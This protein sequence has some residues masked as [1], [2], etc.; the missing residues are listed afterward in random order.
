MHSSGSD[1]RYVVRTQGPV[2]GSS[3]LVG[4]DRF[5]DDRR[6]VSPDRVFRH[7]VIAHPVGPGNV[8]YYPLYL[9]HDLQVLFFSGGPDIEFHQYF[10]RDDVLP[11]SP[12]IAPTV[13]E[14]G[15]PGRFSLLTSVWSVEMASAAVT[16]G[17][18]SSGEA[19]RV[20]HTADGHIKCC[21]SPMHAPFPYRTVPAAIPVE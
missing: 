8:V 11:G 14:T 13:I 4:K 19:R 18:S 5:G 2:Q 17:R 15:L 10:F 16:T 3:Y 9:F 6:G 1:D 7:Q 12:W 21:F 20:R